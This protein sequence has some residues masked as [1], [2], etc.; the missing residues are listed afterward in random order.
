MHADIPLILTSSLLGLFCIVAFVEHS[1]YGGFN[2][3]YYTHGLPFII[4]RI[5]VTAS[6]QD[7]PPVS[8]LQE[9]F[10]S[11]LLG[12]LVFQQIAPD[13]YGFRRRFFQSALSP[14]NL[15]HGML[16]FDRENSRVVLK[17]FINGLVPWL[18]LA[19]WVF[20]VLGPLPGLFRLLPLAIV[21]LVIGIP[22]GL[23]YRRCVKLARF[24]AS[25]WNT[26]PES[27]KHTI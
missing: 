18:V 16:L 3:R 13:T 19:V 27:S 15:M 9:Q 8:L 23:E 14:N 17:C 26:I 5:P 22:L 24:A 4:Q 11:A 20:S 10:R 7:L 2:H 21:G 12:S 25:A 1:L 6:H